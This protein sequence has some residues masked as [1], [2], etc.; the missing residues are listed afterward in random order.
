MVW[1]ALIVGAADG[2]RPR[3]KL[4]APPAVI[5]AAINDGMPLGFTGGAREL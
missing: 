5:E 1:A 3:S 4:A 2:Q